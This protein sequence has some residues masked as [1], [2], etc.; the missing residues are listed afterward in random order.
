MSVSF[1]GLPSSKSEAIALGLNRYFTG[2][3]CKNGG[4]SIRRTTNGACLCDACAAIRKQKHRD[5]ALK[6]AGTRRARHR[7]YYLANREAIIARQLQRY[8]NSRDEY[9]TRHLSWR[10][11]NW[12]VVLAHAAKRRASK[13]ER[14]PGWFG[15]LD[16]LIFAEAVSL[17]IERAQATGFP[18][19][20]DHM[21][22]LM[23]KTVCGLHCGSNLQ[24]IP[25]RLNLQKQNR[26]TLTE[27][28]QWITFI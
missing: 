19:H 14:I 5:W 22:P 8:H 21:I 6:N 18:W 9:R 15:E 4:I 7:E 27:P 23:G 10:A 13:R 16:Q 24:V 12:H 2:M 17:S 28:G 25:A 11:R 3:P 1:D 26:L 20:A